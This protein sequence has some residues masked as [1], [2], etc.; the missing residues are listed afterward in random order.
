MD[1]GW[2]IGMVGCNRCNEGGSNGEGEKV[3]EEE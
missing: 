1:G 3:W 2:W